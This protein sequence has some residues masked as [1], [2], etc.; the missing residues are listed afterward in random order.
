MF[1]GPQRIMD[2]AGEGI[3]APIYRYTYALT[4]E[5][6]LDPLVTALVFHFHLKQGADAFKGNSKIVY[7][8]LT[9][10]H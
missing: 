2:G 7:A 6:D 3:S 10:D 1:S 5:D 8:W 9:A 4:L